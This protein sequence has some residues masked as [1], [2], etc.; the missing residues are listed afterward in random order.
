MTISNPI[1]RAKYTITHIDAS[2]YVHIGSLQLDNT[3]SGV[4]NEIIRKIGLL[5]KM[6]SPS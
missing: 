6:H 2:L 3:I 1:T 5:L 4:Q